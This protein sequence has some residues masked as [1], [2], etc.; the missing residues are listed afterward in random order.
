MELRSTRKLLHILGVPALAIPFIAALVP[1]RVWVATWL[2]IWL[3]FG[4]VL[5]AVNLRFWRCPFCGKHFGRDVPQYCPHCGESL[6]L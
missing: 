1:S 4:A 6:D 3:L 5:V 2:V